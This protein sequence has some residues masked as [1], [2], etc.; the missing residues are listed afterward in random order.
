MHGIVPPLS[1]T[2]GVVRMPAPQLGE[3][4]REILCG[5]GLTEAD[6]ARLTAQDVI[7]QG[8]QRRKSAPP[9]Q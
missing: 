2:P 8:K 1:E 6:L 7:Y 5:L 3:H 9:A 4:N